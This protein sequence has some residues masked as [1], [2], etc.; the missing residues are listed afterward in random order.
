MG[1]PENKPE[2]LH[3]D[4]FDVHMRYIQTSLD[5]IRDM[6]VK[7]ADRLETQERTLYR[8]TITV[9]EHHKRSTNIE[10]RQEEFVLALRSITNDITTIVAKLTIIGNELEPIK[11]KADMN[12][13]F[14]N[15]LLWIKDNKALIFKL[16]TIVGIASIVMYILLKDVEAI[17]QLIK[18]V[19]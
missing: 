18:V 4:V 5:S 8:N 7:I 17:K 6:S 15:R 9:E 3:R 19:F 16:A 14:I 2:F 12:D 13:K 10:H 11:A 1:S